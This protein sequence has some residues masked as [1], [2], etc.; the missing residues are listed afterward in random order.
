[1]NQNQTGRHAANGS[2]D[3]IPLILIHG[4][5]HH[6]P[7][8][9]R[10]VV[11]QALL[12]AKISGVDPIEFNWDER[13]KKANSKDDSILSGVWNLGTAMANSAWLGN[14]AHLHR[15]HALH[16][17]LRFLWT[18]L[19]LLSAIN[20]IAMLWLG[21]AW[22]NSRYMTEIPSLRIG[23]PWTSYIF[24]PVP[25]PVIAESFAA[26]EMLL[27]FTWISI[28]V[29]GLFLTVITYITTSIGFRAV[30]RQTLLQLAWPPVY[31]VGIL[32]AFL[33]GLGC[34]SIVIGF[35]YI[36]F[37][38]KYMIELVDGTSWYVGPGFGELIISIGMA[39]GLFILA[40]LA[41]LMLWKIL[42]PIFDVFRYLGDS[43][44][45]AF[46]HSEL[47]SEIQKLPK[48]RRVIIAAHSLGSVIA[49]DSLLSH[50]ETWDKFTRIDLI[51]AGSPLKRFLSRFFPSAYPAPEV[52]SDALKC[53]F[54]SIRW[55]NIYRISDYIGGG[56]NRKKR[57]AIEGIPIY[58]RIWKSHSN[59]WQDPYVIKCL[60]DNFLAPFSEAVQIAQRSC[61]DIDLESMT[62]WQRVVPAPEKPKPWI[63]KLNIPICVLGFLFLFWFQF[64]WIPEQ[65]KKNLA[66]WN[67]LC[68]Q[69]GGAVDGRLQQGEFID[70]ATESMM[71]FDVV[72]LSY[73]VGGKLYGA[74]S[75]IFWLPYVT[76]R[77]PHI[78][79][80][81]LKK[82]LKQSNLDHMTVNIE[83]AK[84]HPRIFR[85]PNYT[86][87]PSYYSLG[88]IFFY[89]IRT[90]ILSVFWILW[91]I[92]LWSLLRGL[93]AQEQTTLVFNGKS[94]VDV[95]ERRRNN[96]DSQFDERDR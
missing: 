66:E 6:R 53:T 59:Y 27:G 44:V 76:Q 40:F 87:T 5:G 86:K 69:N 24:P 68:D 12:D 57:T 19:P 91:S 48:S 28:L 75:G 21:L 51:T 73:K 17:V 20:M 29:Y 84:N 15:G 56:L 18:I 31:T 93:S 16:R 80:K 72:A 81:K 58:R 38:L 26:A 83:Y 60:T 62:I 22:L 74:E 36:L 47:K 23:L 65:E 54:E 41:G 4:V 78:D 96:D 8:K 3:S 82:E 43:Q 71:R 14:D 10:D 67:F 39:V 42:K 94:T 79:F 77:F 85:V 32:P 9:I 35:L 37:N 30:T 95:N 92:F 61:E 49:V 7:G 52:L 55:I 90:A 64:V 13:I 34:A 2:I 11:H 46:I 63:T 88:R 50:R 45:R 1:L 33:T 89:F 70:T 25:A